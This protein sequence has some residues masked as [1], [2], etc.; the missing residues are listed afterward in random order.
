[1]NVTVTNPHNPSYNHTVQ[2]LQP[3]KFEL[4]SELLGGKMT[5]G[6]TL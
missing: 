1:M 6:E 2:T 4:E 3:M 5:L